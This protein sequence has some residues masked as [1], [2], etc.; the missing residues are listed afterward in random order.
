M[1]DQLDPAQREALT[2]AIGAAGQV[3]Q[4]GQRWQHMD[5]QDSPASC[6][7]VA[8]VAAD[9]MSQLAQALSETTFS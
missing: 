3:V 7:T 2:P 4:A 6:L 9:R 1:I 8:A 5:C